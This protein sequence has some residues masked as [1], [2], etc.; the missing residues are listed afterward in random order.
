MRY[1]ILSIGPLLNTMGQADNT[2]TL[3]TAS[4]I[5]SNLMKD[6]L[7]HLFHTQNIKENEFVLPAIDKE[8]FSSGKRAGLFHDRLILRGDKTKEIQDAFDFAIGELVKIVQKAFKKS[9]G[10]K[11]VKIDFDDNEVEAFVKSYIQSYI[12]SVDVPNGK[13]PILY[14][15]PFVDIA[16]YEPK[17]PIH[18]EKEYLYKFL[19]IANL[20]LNKYF[21]FL[22]G[23]EDGKKDRCFKSLPEIASH[24]FVKDWD[25]KNKYFC[26]TINQMKKLEE[27][28]KS[29]EWEV[30]DIYDELLKDENIKEK[31]K[32][33]HKYVAIVQA[34]GDSFA[35]HL[36]SIGSDERK[37]KE[38]SE[39]IFKF[40]DGSREIIEKSGGA[41]IIAGGDDLLFFAPVVANGLNIFELIDKID[42]KFACTFCKAKGLSMSYGISISYHKFPLQESLALANRALFGEA[43][44]SKWVNYGYALDTLDKDMD[45]LKLPSKNAIHLNIQKHSGQSHALTL[46]KDTELY[47]LFKK[48]LKAE[49]NENEDLHLPHALH[50]S[51]KKSEEII[52]CLEVDSIEHFFTNQFDEDVHKTTHKEALEAVQEI[53]KYLKDSDESCWRLQQDRDKNYFLS[54]TTQLL[55]E[56]LSTIK[57]LR[58]DE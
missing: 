52:E 3:W 36:A 49:L 25:K 19:K 45:A 41:V 22:E 26:L 31:F 32:P 43:K 21:A 53:I 48:L 18:Q 24:D 56:L 9:N 37:L 27:K 8:Y 39:N 17:L 10:Y 6:T 35:K 46:K 40:A 14:L 1:T 23:A 38:F 33:Y 7:M 11:Y 5:F 57:L 12:V 2:R 50:H 55:F 34:D 30:D 51:L 20:T 16:E 44:K 4:Y 13:S 29:P 58:G 15:S 42:E 47:E 28:I 54:K